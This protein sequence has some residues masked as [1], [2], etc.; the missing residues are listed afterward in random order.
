[1][2]KITL[3]NVGS[4]ID[5]TTA[6]NTINANNAVIQTA[7]DNTLSRDGTAPNQMNNP[8][9]MNS[10][11]I[12]NLPNPATANS[13]LRLQDL[14][15]FIGGGIVTNIP[16]GGTTGQVLGKNSNTNFDTAWKN[17]VTSVGL[18]LPSD[19]TVTNSP[20]TTT[21]T[22]TGAWATTPTGTGAMVRANSPTLVTPSLG[23]AS[24]STL[25]GL[26]L[27]PSSGTLTLNTNSL[28]IPGSGVNINLQG[29]PG[30]TTQTFPT[31]NATLARTDSGQT[32][33]GT[34]IFNGQIA[35]NSFVTIG[36]SNAQSLLVGASGTN[37]V[38]Q[39]DSSTASQVAGLKITGA[40]T[41]G[42]VAIAVLDSGANA[43]LDIAAKGTGTINI[44]QNSSGAVNI[45]NAGAIINLGQSGS[46]T[47]NVGKANSASG[48]LTISGSTSGAISLQP[49]A[50][51]SGLLT[52]P[53]GTD[54]I[55]ANAATQTLSNKTLTSP[56]M[57]TPTLGVASA[58]TINKV[59][60]TAPATG[61]T[62]TVADGKTLASNNTLT[63]AGTDGSTLNAGVGGTLTGSSS[64][65][66]WYDNIPQNSQS[67]AYTLVLSDA[68]KHLFH[69]S[70]DTT[71]RTWTIPANASVAYPIGTAVTF[72]NQNAGGVITIAITTD[73]MRLAGAGTTG[74]RTLAA[75]G[76]ATALKVTA[77]EWIISGTGLT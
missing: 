72:V 10:M 39:V 28:G 2:T 26:T 11:Q 33:T 44:A 43:S 66:I 48:T 69:P 76:I 61:S 8:L 71:A 77:T 32:F 54:T 59:T 64:S 67:A 55:T 58:T 35:S 21:G 17:S 27:T 24:V 9:D 30:V 34:Q 70:A 1:M 42:T 25:N 45:G 49:T 50:A 15:S 62:L 37:P 60:L 4:L 13:P 53:N 52:L 36:S 31:T 5:A 68:Q 40:V 46:T 47:L 74:S 23:V 20:V 18:S 65:A 7:F 12:V 51:A 6:Q 38:F 57:T 75:N 56:V 63:L 16:S 22:L 73:T 14:T 29:G 41:G 3:N 19:L